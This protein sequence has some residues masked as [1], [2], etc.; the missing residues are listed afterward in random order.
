MF[1]TNSLLRVATRCSFAQAVE[2]GFGLK[3]TA[4][5]IMVQFGSA[6]A[7]FAVDGKIMSGTACQAVRPENRRF[8]RYLVRGVQAVGKDVQVVCGITKDSIGNNGRRLLFVDARY[9]RPPSTGTITGEV[10]SC[11]MLSAGDANCASRQGSSSASNNPT[12]VNI[13]T[14]ALPHDRHRHFVYR[15]TIPDQAMLKSLRY[16]EDE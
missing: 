7:A 16:E 11:S 12:S 10:F 2:K 13:D 8:L 4:L 14:R 1:S 6:P 9:Q 3:C 5:L 15:T